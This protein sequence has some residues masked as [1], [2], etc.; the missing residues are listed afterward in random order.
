MLTDR[1]SLEYRSCRPF[2]TQG[3][4]PPTELA[5]ELAQKWRASA[6]SPGDYP[7]ELWFAGRACSLTGTTLQNWIARLS[8]LMGCPAD[9]TRANKWHKT[10]A[11]QGFSVLSASL[12][13][14]TFN[15]LTYNAP[16]SGAGVRSAEASAPLAGYISAALSFL[17]ANP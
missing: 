13:S 17:V 2:Q 12:P 4:F 10:A 1:H 8:S 3:A 14:L 5:R 7:R 11:H 15:P 6:S 16:M 9:S